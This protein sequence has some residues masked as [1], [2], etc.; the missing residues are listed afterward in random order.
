MSDAQADACRPGEVGGTHAILG[1]GLPIVGIM[2]G[3]FVRG[4]M[5]WLWIPAFTVMGATCVI[6]VRR[7]GRVHCYATGPLFLGMAL[8]LIVVLLGLAPV[9]WINLA[10]IALVVG[11]ILAYGSELIVGRYRS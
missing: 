10:S 6:N 1:W 8:F 3:S 4:L 2:I 11:I 5:F 9:K 7:C